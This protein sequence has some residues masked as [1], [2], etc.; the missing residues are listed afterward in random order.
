MA[1]DVFQKSCFSTV[2]ELYLNSLHQQ[3]LGGSVY[4]WNPSPKGAHRQMDS[5]NPVNSQT[6]K[7]NEVW[8]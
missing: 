4:T 5:G 8:I 6:S 3:D 1:G 7:N 2:L